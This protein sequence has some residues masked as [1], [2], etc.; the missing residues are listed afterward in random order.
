MNVIFRFKF[1]QRVW[2]LSVQTWTICY[3]KQ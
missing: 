1:E 2:V 3:D